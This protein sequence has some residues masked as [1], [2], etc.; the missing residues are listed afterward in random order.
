MCGCRVYMC[1]QNHIH[2]IAFSTEFHNTQQVIFVV[3]SAYCFAACRLR[4]VYFTCGDRF[5]LFLLLFFENFIFWSIF[6]I[7]SNKIFCWPLEFR[8]KWVRKIWKMCSKV[9]LKER[10]DV[11]IYQN[12]KFLHYME[13]NQNNENQCT[14]YYFLFLLFSTILF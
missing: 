9:P 6:N 10:L 4:F 13:K 2:F 14:D 12:Y 7:V 3:I 8:L 5:F 1:A 11:L